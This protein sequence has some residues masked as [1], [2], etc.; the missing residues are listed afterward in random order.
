MILEKSYTMP[1]KI[2]QRGLLCIKIETFW[3]LEEKRQ[4][5]REG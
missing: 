4:Q 2:I 3:F 5:S 1:P